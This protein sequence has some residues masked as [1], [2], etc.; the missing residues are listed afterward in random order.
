MVGARGD[1]K[2]AE[3]ACRPRASLARRAAAA[4]ALAALAAACRQE[5]P[6]EVP[7]M[8]VVVDTDL[9]VPRAVSHLRVDIFG[10]DGAW[11]HARDYPAPRAEDWPLSFG[12]ASLDEARSTQVLVRLRAYPEGATRDY[13]GERWEGPAPYEPPDLPKS[14]DELCARAP[15]LPPSN[16]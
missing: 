11:L 12:V 3:R 1:R 16:R 14:R 7:A 2:T 13:L 8:L 10:T 4:L 5:A 9:P 15:L 6:P